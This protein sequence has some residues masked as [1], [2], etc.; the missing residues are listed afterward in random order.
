MCWALATP[1]P[2][3]KDQKV[4]VLSQIV[5]LLLCAVFSRRYVF[6]KNC[7]FASNKIKKELDQPGWCLAKGRSGVCVDGGVGCGSV[8]L[9]WKS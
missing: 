2:C 6:A 1:H 9:L 3:H 8:W 4:V 7:S 5:L